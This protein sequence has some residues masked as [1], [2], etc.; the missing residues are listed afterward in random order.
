MAPKFLGSLSKTNRCSSVNGFDALMPHSCPVRLE[1]CPAICLIF[2]SLALRLPPSYQSPILMSS[3]NLSLTTTGPVQ[4]S[5]R[6]LAATLS[7]YNPITKGTQRANLQ[8]STENK[9]GCRWL[10]KTERGKKKKK[11]S[12]MCTMG[13]WGIS[14]KINKFL[15]LKIS[16]KSAFFKPRRRIRKDYAE[17]DGNT[18]ERFC[19]NE[20]RR[21]R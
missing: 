9:H 19:L 12:H 16:S 21:Q 6:N 2:L 15:S 4:T 5:A 8:S 20:L 3:S 17:I 1:E 11:K 14:K 18:R 10:R 13:P 7:N